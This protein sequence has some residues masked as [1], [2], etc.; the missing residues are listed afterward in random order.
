MKI[1]SVE[2]FVLKDKL[3][4]SFYF[5]QWSYAER[6]ICLVKVTTEDGLVGW[7]EG[8]G[9]AEVLSAGVKYLEQFVIGANP[10]NNEV[11]WETLYRRTLDY[12]R[13]G[14]LMAS[15][16][17]IDVAIWD[18]KGKMLGLPVHQLLGGKMRDKIYP[19]ATG[20]Y[21]RE[22]KNLT[23]SLA[24]EAKAYADLGYQAVKMKVGMTIEDDIRNVRAV[25]AAIGDKV[26]LM[27]DA[28]HAYNLREAIQLCKAIEDQNIAWFEEPISPE[29][30]EQ[31]AELRAATSIP[32]SGGEC[33]YLRYGFHQL[34][35]HKAVDILQPDICASGGLTEAK[36]IA[37]LASTYG[38]E[39][40][41]HS[42]GTYIAISAAVHFIANLESV[43][44]R[45]IMPDFT[46]EHD[47]TTNGIR[48][49]VT[50]PSFEVKNGELVVPDTPGLGVEVN[51]EVLNKYRI[52]C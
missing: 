35:K 5:S 6:K 8:Y 11:I 17:A 13:K 12:A 43:P 19:Y 47:R 49:L 1:K 44:G 4:K 32:I 38:I 33:E 51:E 26:R 40:V 7:G 22:E 15:V 14:I 34:L 36:R 50:F 29:F 42:W 20:M 39:V 18:L 3:E 52:D 23:Q 24:D 28:N 16:S 45:L 9:P 41:P 10:L 30:Y 31:H 37:T 21:F 27:I 48:D 25:R 46:M 2:A